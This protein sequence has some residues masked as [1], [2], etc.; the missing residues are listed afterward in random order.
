MQP[1]VTQKAALK[2]QKSTEASQ[3]AIAPYI[4]ETTLILPLFY[5]FLSQS[6]ALPEQI[7]DFRTATLR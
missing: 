3:S 2:I 6:Q 1:E 7:S 5:Y 4:V